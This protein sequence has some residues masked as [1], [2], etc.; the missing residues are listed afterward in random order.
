MFHLQ[1]NDPILCL[2]DTLVGNCQ[3]L[4][5]GKDGKKTAH[6]LVGWRTEGRGDID[7]QTFY[8]TDLEPQ[9]PTRFSVQIPLNA[10]PS[11]DGELLRIIWEVAVGLKSKGAFTGFNKDKPVETR[12]FRVIVPDRQH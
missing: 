1:I 7:Q 9:T 12:S 8:E 10:P 6:L 5:D 2:G 4:P 3:W 11:Y